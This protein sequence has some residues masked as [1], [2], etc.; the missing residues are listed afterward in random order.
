MTPPP[1]GHRQ[2]QSAEE[3]GLLE[4]YL[5]QGRRLDAAFQRI[6]QLEANE[7]ERDKGILRIVEVLCRMAGFG[8]WDGISK[9]IADKLVGGFLFLSSIKG[10]NSRFW[11]YAWMMIVA[12]IS[13]ASGVIMA[14][15]KWP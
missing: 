2:P 10:G 9:D 15:I 13:G 14:K 12:V 4:Q 1:D 8:T 6:E 11:R 7:K 3:I 5:S